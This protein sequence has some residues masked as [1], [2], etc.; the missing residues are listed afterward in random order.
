M[1]EED[2]ISYL[3]GSMINNFN[4]LTTSDH[5]EIID[6][7]INVIGSDCS[8][9]K[10]IFYLEMNDW[11][12]HKSICAYFD[13]AKNN[14]DSNR[15]DYTDLSMKHIKTI[16]SDANNLTTD[17]TGRATI[18]S[19]IFQSYLIKNNGNKQWPDGCYLVIS[20]PLAALCQSTIPINNLTPSESQ[21]IQIK[22]I[23][24]QDPCTVICTITLCSAY[25]IAF[26]D[27]IWLVLYVQSEDSLKH[28][29]VPS[30]NFD[31]DEM[32]IDETMHRLKVLRLYKK[33]LYTL[34]FGTSSANTRVIKKVRE[35]FDLF[36]DTEPRQ[37]RRSLVYGKY[38]LDQFKHLETFK[39]YRYMY[40]NY[41][42]KYKI[43]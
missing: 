28:N 43:K 26:G 11:N 37:I 5:D 25:G 21:V 41:D 33:F 27:K 40:K 7:F 9:N 36:K 4:Q 18:G 30:I 16:T 15:E 8:K 13:Y 24:P 3:T 32:S 1:D 34:S 39:K 12:I 6:K 23:C 31:N 17:T 2:D 38:K 42:E 22:I 20:A 29:E 14:Q 19:T 35:T 10:A